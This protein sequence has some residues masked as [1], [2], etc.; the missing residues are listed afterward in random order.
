MTLLKILL[1][2]DTMLLRLCIAEEL[3]DLGHEVIEAPSGE[4]AI[5][6]LSTGVFDGVIL[7]VQMP[8]GNGLSVLH[9]MEAGGNTPP[10][11]VQSSEPQFRTAEH[12]LL[13]LGT[14]IPNVFGQFARFRLKDGNMIENVLTFIAGIAPQ[15]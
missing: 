9:Y 3:R 5:R 2:D 10:T 1:A 13:E 6:A 15:Q 11:L 7:D 12:G 4:A 8:P 14:V